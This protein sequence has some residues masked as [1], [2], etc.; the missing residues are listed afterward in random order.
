MPKIKPFEEHVDRYEEWFVRNRFA[1]KSKLQA[2]RVMLPEGGT[3]IEIGVGTGRFA[4]PLGI[5]LG[6]EP[7]KAMRQIAQRKRAIEV[8]CG[9]AEALPL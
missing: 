7:S 9:V 8:I 2:I 4:A 3:G 5:K 1:Y 6:I